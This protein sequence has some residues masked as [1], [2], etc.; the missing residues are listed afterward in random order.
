M[1]TRA[2]ER[3]GIEERAD[4]VRSVVLDAR[5][6]CDLEMV[7]TGAFSPLQGFMNRADYEA[8]VEHSRLEGGLPW[9]TPVTLA[10][11][12]ETARAVT[13]DTIALRDREE[14]LLGILEVEDVYT[15]DKRR[16]AENIYRTVDEAHPGVR[17]LMNRPDWLVGGKVRVI[18]RPSRSHAALESVL[19]DP[20]ETRLLF[21]IK[22]W[23]TIVAFQT[24]NPVHRAHEYIQ[25]AAL[26]MVD[27]LLLHPLVGATKEDDIP[28]D[29]RL[30]CYRVLLDNYFPPGR[31]VLSVLP[32]AMRY[33]GPRE[34]IHHAIVRKNYGCTHIIIGRDHAG[35]G[36]YYGP[37]DAQRA[38]A[39]F[40]PGELEITPLFFDNAF[41]CRQCQGMASDKTCPHPPDRRVNLSGTAVRQ[42]LRSGERLPPEYS[43]P[44]VVEILRA[45]YAGPAPSMASDVLAPA[46]P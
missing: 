23:R 40:A 27:G 21:E 10:V 6:V 17:Y 24:R 32:A 9:T 45:A 5:E 15:Y 11:T 16:E 28:A 38:F 26:E 14:A 37:Y 33:A 20:I 8:V 41:F 25:K 22:G 18:R 13:G 3:E 12:P 46:R 19:L 31:A 7:A 44:E 43:R 2:D 35:V 39:D 34:A 29:V 4:G 30:R 36:G 42:L 1:V